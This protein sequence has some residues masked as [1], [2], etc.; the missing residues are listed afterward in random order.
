MMRS[1]SM[2]GRRMGGVGLALLVF[3]LPLMLACAG[4]R[5]P[6]QAM[7][8]PR[9][10]PVTVSTAVQK[11]VPLQ[12]TAIG[13]V[14]PMN[15]VQVK[16]MISGEITGVA[17]KEGQD[18]RKGQLLFTIDRRAIE[19]DLRRAQAT[20]AK[21]RATQLQA[22]ADAARYAALGKEG[23]VA[24]QM[25]DQME[26]SA[27]AADELVRADEAAVQNAKVQLQYAEIYSPINGRTGN[28]S[29]QLGNVVKANDASLVS[30][31]Q[32]AP[33]YVT[34]SIPEQYLA[35]VKKYG[36]L[37]KLAVAAAIP[38]DPQ[39][40]L[41]VLTFVDNAVDR[42]TG[43]IKLKGT[44][45]NADRRLWPGQFVN[46]TLTLATQPNALVVPTQ[47]VQNGQDGQYVY[48]IRA[49]NTAESRP[50]KIAR[51]VGGQAVVE[52][53]IAPGDKVVTDGQLRL[54]PGVKVEIRNSGPSEGQNAEAATAEGKQS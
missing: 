31:N 3:V 45:E 24:R 5:K 4:G 17:F 12:I 7:A 8:G 47:A 15:T 26:A 2:W 11:D 21:D 48:V 39:P 19:A 54:L 44:F 16:T 36:A 27:N 42:Q 18:V 29:V 34:F 37:H 9:T 33:I 35:E 6:D 23:V 30:I 13:A 32:V 40:A 51:T 50:V 14:E 10:V 53:G 43:T 52:S 25:A 22:R 49:D 38:N 20:L 28:L 1:N 46:V 41:G